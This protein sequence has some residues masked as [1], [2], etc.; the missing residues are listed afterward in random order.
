MA[1]ILTVG[2]TLLECG[3]C[4]EQ[5]LAPDGPENRFGRDNVALPEVAEFIKKHRDGCPQRTLVVPE[6]KP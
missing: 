4:H 2:C 6:S 5:I 3:T 1:I